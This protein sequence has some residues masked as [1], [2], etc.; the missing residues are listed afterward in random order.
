MLIKDKNARCVMFF[1]YSSFCCVVFIEKTRQATDDVYNVEGMYITVSATDKN[2]FT[3][4]Q[5]RKLSKNV[6][7][8]YVGCV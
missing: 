6:G 3:K 4:K 1:V 2:L 5:D 7:T 8:Y